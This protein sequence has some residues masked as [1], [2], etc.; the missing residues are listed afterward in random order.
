MLLW[1]SSN[2]A[3][4]KKVTIMDKEKLAQKVETINKELAAIIRAERTNIEAFETPFFRQGSI[5]KV[6][7]LGEIRPMA[8]TIGVAESNFVVLL[9]LNS[10]GFEE[11]KEKS[12]FLFPELIKDQIQYVLTFLETTRSFSD[13]FHILQEFEEIEL[14]PKPTDKEKSS[15]TILKEKYKS[16]IKPPSFINDSQFIVFAIKKRDLVKITAK[17]SVN[18]KIEC[19]ETILEK[20]I[21]IAYTR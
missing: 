5:Y 17:L 4:G 14:I 9:P 10:K 6:V 2:E 12:D 21:P 19:V 3:Q 7:H 20:D 18:G 1:V 8:F 11:L 16:L 15:Y 13:N